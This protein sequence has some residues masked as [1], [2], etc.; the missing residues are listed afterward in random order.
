MLSKCEIHNVNG[1][2]IKSFDENP[3][4]TGFIRMD[5]FSPITSN[6]TITDREKMQQHGAWPT[7]PFR[8]GMSID[9]EGSIQ[10][11]TPAN[12]LA[13]LDILTGAL[14]GTPADTVSRRN[15]TLFLR[16]LDKTEDWKTDIIV[17]EF[18]APLTA[19][20]TVIQYLV[21]LFSFTPYFTG[22]TTGSFFYWT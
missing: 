14:F 9:I 10:A 16:R 6:R 21:T 3:V 13:Q 17:L 8:G 2:G 12:A 20:S 19:D 4:S 22:V 11:N 18:S 7:K 5:K 15:G 1:F